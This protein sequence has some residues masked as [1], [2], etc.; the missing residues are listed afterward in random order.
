MA[1]EKHAAELAA[2]ESCRETCRHV[3]ST[4]YRANRLIEVVLDLA[5]SRLGGGITVQPRAADMALVCRAA[6]HEVQMSYP[7][8]RISF[9]ATGDLRGEWDVDRVS[10]VVGNLLDNAIKHG[11]KAEGVKVRVRGDDAVVLTV[12]NAGAIPPERMSTLFE[13][14]QRGTQ[15]REG[16]G[17]GLYIV[18][19]IVRAHGGTVAATSTAADGTTFTVTWPRRTARASAA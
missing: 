2:T 9:E 7:D 8:S 5:R 12:H 15:R 10:Q 11:A 3:T 19:Q 18:D 17:L 4:V 13:P 1:A 16:L 14:F 6:I